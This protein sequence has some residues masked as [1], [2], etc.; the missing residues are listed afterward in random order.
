MFVAECIQTWSVRVWQVF[1]TEA[2]GAFLRSPSKHPLLRLAANP[3]LADLKTYTRW[4][5]RPPFHCQAAF[6]T[7]FA[8][9]FHRSSPF[10]EA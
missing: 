3:M 7:V 9:C 6:V 4:K 10:R 8:E 5:A 2:I 1:T